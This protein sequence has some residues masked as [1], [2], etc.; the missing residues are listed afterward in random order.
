MGLLPG[1]GFELLEKAPFNGPLTIS[2][3]AEEKIIGYKAAG[4][5]LVLATSGE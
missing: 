5:I 3:S 1:T 4:K 2:I